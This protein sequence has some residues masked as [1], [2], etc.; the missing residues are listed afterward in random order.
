LDSR[1][2][3]IVLFV[4]VDAIARRFMIMAGPLPA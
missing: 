4:I 1:L 3:A 2:S